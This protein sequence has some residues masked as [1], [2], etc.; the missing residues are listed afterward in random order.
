MDAIYQCYKKNHQVEFVLE[1]FYTN[2]GGIVY[3][4]SDAG[5]DFSYLK[6][7]YKD[8]LIY[9]YNSEKTW[10]DREG[11]VSKAQALHWMIWYTEACR[12]L[13]SKHII[14]LED[15][16]YIRGDLNQIEIPYDIMGPPSHI[17]N[18]IE[19][20][21]EQ[22]VNELDKKNIPLK[23]YSGC[24]GS[25]MN[26]EIIAAGEFPYLINNHYENLIKLSNKML[27][28]DALITVLYRLLG[29][30][31]GVNTD[32]TEPWLNPNWLNTSE[33]I[34]HQF[35]FIKQYDTKF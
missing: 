15:D 8:R 26:R 29:Y 24:G 19:P 20:S 30:G 33:K 13:I 3:L 4:L 1:N 6:E 2:G 11:W 21:I 23:F 18:Q 35:E 16:V 34:V 22:Y 17:H 28:S 14:L 9:K 12:R 7:I 32:Y 31:N 10:C 25:I 27:F 5:N